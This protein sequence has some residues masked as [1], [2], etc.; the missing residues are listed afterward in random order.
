[1]QNA[2]D[3]FG[4][5][6]LLALAMALLLIG[7]AGLIYVGF[8]WDIRQGRTFHAGAG[9]TLTVLAPTR[10][11]VSDTAS[12]GV[13]YE[14]VPD[15]EYDSSGNPLPT[16]GSAHVTVTLLAPS[17]RASPV[18]GEP[19]SNQVAAESVGN[20]LWLIFPESLGQQRMVLRF[21]G[22]AGPLVAS[23]VDQLGVDTVPENAVIMDTL[24]RPVEEI[25][26]EF[27]NPKYTYDLVIPVTV[28]DLFG[29]TALQARLLGF[30]LA[31][32]GNGF[33]AAWLYEQWQ[34]RQTVKAKK[35]HS[36]RSRKAARG[37]SSRG[38]RR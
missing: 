3:T 13:Q 24:D 34:K 23:V 20:W 16:A 11:R 27:R 10:L 35:S 18:T 26:E 17:F 9:D 22:L 29:F 7:V 38:K 36:G 19:I 4:R 12:V 8:T 6:W 25:V 21:Q 31:F 37:A 15:L 5:T 14:F 33:T 2:R 30:A 28:V 1:M 32:V